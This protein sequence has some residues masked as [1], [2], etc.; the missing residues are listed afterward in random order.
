[1]NT[2]NNHKGE[3]SKWKALLSHLK[4]LENP[5][6]LDGAFSTVTPRTDLEYLADFFCLE[7]PELVADI[8]N[9]YIAFIKRQY[10]S[11]LFFKM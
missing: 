8:H 10:T 11:C 4:G 6:V 2:I 1:M 5:I 7:N 9:K 3:S